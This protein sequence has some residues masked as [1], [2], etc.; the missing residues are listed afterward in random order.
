MDKMKKLRIFASAIL[1]MVCAVMPA[2]AQNKGGDET[3][4]EYTFNPHLFIQAQGGIQYTLGET[5][6][7]KLLSPNVQIGV[8][9]EFTPSIAARLSLNAWQ[10]KGGFDKDWVFYNLD[11]Y[12]WKFTYLA[13]SIDAML[14]LTNLIGG[15]NPERKIGVGILA[16]IGMNVVLN[17]DEAGDV[18]KDYTEKATGDA[19]NDPAL[20]QQTKDDIAARILPYYD[21][22][23]LYFPIRFGANVDWHINDNWSLG[24]ELNANSIGDEY[25]SKQDHNHSIGNSDW[26]FNTLLGVKYCFGSTYDKKAKE[27]M[28][29]VSNAADYAPECDPVEKVVEKIVE[30]PVEVFKPSLYEEIYYDINKDKISSNEKYKIR[31]IVEFMNENPEATIEIAGHADRATGTS[32]YNQKLSQRRA[33]NVAKA[34]KDAGI[35]ESRITVSYHGSADNIYDGADMN[36]NRVSICT[37]K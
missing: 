32:E 28:I 6:F 22:K 5:A 9:Y 33:D 13:P 18:K 8:G 24:L 14:D 16:G 30:T 36:L 37:A 19:Y 29:P 12:E 15:F 1:V 25:N 20:S 23:S 35:A 17:N 2:Q 4:Y 31:R 7:S 21:K 10:S 34:L 27:K 26:Y 3:E 11:N